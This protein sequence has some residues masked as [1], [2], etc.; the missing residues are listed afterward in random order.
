MVLYW[1]L[2]SCCSENLEL[3]ARLGSET[4]PLSESLSLQSADDAS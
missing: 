2:V 3:I 1:I 4:F